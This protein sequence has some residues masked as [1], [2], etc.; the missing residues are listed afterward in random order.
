MKPR[1][2]LQRAIERFAQDPTSVRNATTV[3]I[4]LTLGIVLV[5]GVV[6]WVFDSQDFPDLGSALWYTLQ[7]ATTVGYGD[8]VPTTLLG[9]LVGATVMIVAVALVAIL[10]AA[11]TSA[12]VEASQRRRRAGDEARQREEVERQARQLDEILARLATIE[13]LLA[14][15]RSPSAPA[16]RETPGEPADRSGSTADR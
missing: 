1:S 4:L 15:D 11:I 16:A 8:M 10:T 12:F 3:I 7:T 2:P 14:A 9:R 13:S 5:G 6:V